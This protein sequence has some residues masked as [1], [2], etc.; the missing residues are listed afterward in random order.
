V[1]ALGNQPWV[2]NN[3]CYSTLRGLGCRPVMPIYNGTLNRAFTWADDQGNPRRMPIAVGG[4]QGVLFAR[5]GNFSDPP[6]LIAVRACTK[7]A[8]NPTLYGDRDGTGTRPVMLAIESTK[9]VNVHGV[10]LSRANFQAAALRMLS[11]IRAVKEE[12]Q[13]KCEVWGYAWF[14]MAMYIPPHLPQARDHVRELERTIAPE[15]DAACV[16]LY[17]W[18]EP[19][20]TNGE[21]WWVDYG[22]VKAWLGLY[23]QFKDRK[24]CL[25][26]PVWQV[27]WPEHAKPEH[28]AMN[29]KPI[30]LELWKRQIDTLVKDGWDLYLWT[31]GTTLDGIR[32][33]LEYAARFGK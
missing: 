6:D 28:V 7:L 11:A 30:P 4:G 12:S 15:L 13:G 10:E 5:E 2:R 31:G 29:G 3:D 8:V 32:P 25:V 19:L 24:V 16:A 21:S 23:P 1:D 22:N 33:H 26:L 18:D 27:I 9:T 20:A 17:N 14:P